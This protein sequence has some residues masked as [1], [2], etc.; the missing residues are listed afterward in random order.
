MGAA[1]MN[2]GVSIPLIT[3]GA[4]LVSHIALAGPPFL[5]DDPEP[6]EFHHW[7]AYV[8][9]TYDRALHGTAIQGPALELNLGAA[10]DLQVHLVVPWARNEP[11]PGTSHS[12]WGDVEL[13]LKFRFL[14]ETENRPQIGIFPVVELPAGNGPRGLGNGRAWVKVPLWI[15][16]S[17]GPWTT[18]GGGGWVFNHAPGH[19]DHA[20]GGWLLQ[21]DLGEKLTLGGEVFAQG[22]DAVDG[23]GSTLANVGG[24][25]HFT[26]GFSILFS[27]GRTIRG[28]RHTVAY[29]GLYWTWGPKSEAPRNPGL[30]LLANPF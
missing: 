26:P 8:F 22:T 6:V 11:H 30:T 24:V 17:W 20:F 21:R 10:P 12:G 14:Q 27:G 4:I 16:K 3:L 25:V 23:R 18:Y 7:E 2:R 19:R 5:T 1:P 15:Q 13:G 28:E 29:L 9:S